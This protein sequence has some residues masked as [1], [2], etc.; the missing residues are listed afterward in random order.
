MKNNKLYVYD[1]SL[2]Q[3]Y[4]HFQHFDQ[5]FIIINSKVIN[6]NESLSD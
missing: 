3:Y 4:L 1:I 6:S 2:F 5:N